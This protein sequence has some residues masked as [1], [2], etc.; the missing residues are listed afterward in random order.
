MFS[1]TSNKEASPLTF[2]TCCGFNAAEMYI[3]TSWERAHSVYSGYFESAAIILCSVSTAKEIARW[4][5]WRTEV[6]VMTS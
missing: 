6:L 2:I 3:G 1:S 4:L 5:V